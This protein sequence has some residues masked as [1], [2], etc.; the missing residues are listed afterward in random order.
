[1]KTE[2]INPQIAIL[3]LASEQILC[4]SGWNDGS[5]TDIDENWNILPTL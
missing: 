2:Y 1:M 3:E 5:V 4:A